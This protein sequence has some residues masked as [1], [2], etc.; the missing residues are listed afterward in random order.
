MAQTMSQRKKRAERNEEEKFEEKKMI[1]K[2]KKQNRVGKRGK[3][4]FEKRKTVQWREQCLCGSHNNA[5]SPAVLL[6][7]IVIQ[8]FFEC[9]TL[10]NTSISSLSASS[11]L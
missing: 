4:K 7:I 10:K 5:Q 3:A 6:V 1:K 9:D 8:P 11:T 2:R